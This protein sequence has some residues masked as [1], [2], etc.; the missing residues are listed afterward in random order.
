MVEQWGPAAPEFR[1]RDPLGGLPD[2]RLQ[3]FAAISTGVTSD[4]GSEGD[5][6]VESGGTDDALKGR[7]RGFDLPRLVGKERRVRRSGSPSQTPEAQ[8][9][10]SSR[11][12]NDDCRFHAQMV[13]DLI[14]I[15]PEFG[16]SE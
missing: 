10:S 16:I 11:L 7:D 3:I 1:P 4:S 14:P 15:T 5:V 13:S 9:R 2:R 6:Q 8:S 12:P